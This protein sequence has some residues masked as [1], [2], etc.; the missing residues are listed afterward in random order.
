[1][2]TLASSTHT[3]T[4]RED[5]V[6]RRPSL[7]RLAALGLLTLV[8][9]VPAAG[10]TGAPD[11]SDGSA[12]STAAAST[13]HSSS[14]TTGR[15][16]TTTSLGSDTTA[17][18]PTTT[19]PATTSTQP[20]ATDGTKRVAYLTFDDGPSARTRQLLAILEEEQVPA[21]FFVMGTQAEKYPG[22][23]R[24]I[25]DGGHVVGVHSWT[26]DYAYVY[27]NTDNF[28][29]DFKKLRDYI[30]RETGVAPNVCRFPGGT[31][32]TVSSKYSDGHI[33]REIV[34]LVRSLGFK[35]YDWNVSSA[36]ASNPPPTKDQ[37][38]ANVVSG[39]KKKD[40]A[41]VL[42]HDADRQDYVDA[43]PVIIAKLRSMG[44]AFETLSPDNPPDSKS[45]AVQ[46]KPS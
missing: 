46:F 5:D 32:N 1:M 28:L 13:T 43:V 26:H 19:G 44:F 6:R 25:V 31:N 3:Q 36:E 7:P 16:S 12:S 30:E 39:C 40:L 38:I 23:L 15:V 2:K 21:T 41:V 37:I 24:E 34:P 8:F 27:K 18:G 42:F 29:S 33:M 22:I 20:P 35:Y 17:A 10:C 14:A 4:F 11:P 45:G 9:L